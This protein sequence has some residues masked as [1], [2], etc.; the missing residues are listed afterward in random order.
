MKRF[1]I[2]CF[3]I[4]TIMLLT[5]CK[6]E[7]DNG[8]VVTPWGEVKQA[9]IPTSD[10]F[11][12]DDIIRGGELIMLT[13]SSPIS[14]STF[15]SVTCSSIAAKYSAQVMS[16]LALV[17]VT[18]SALTMNSE[19][20]ITGPEPPFWLSRWKYNCP[21]PMFEV[22]MYG[23]VLCFAQRIRLVNLAVVL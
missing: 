20:S 4:L 14:G 5:G 7:N 22:W 6:R 1:L 19:G 17:V 16:S 2:A 10:A 8:V 9:E 15:M 23:V 11:S 18:T 3:S 12:L 13:M 21:L